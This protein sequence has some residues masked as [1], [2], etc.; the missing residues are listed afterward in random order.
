MNFYARDRINIHLQKM[1]KNFVS[2]NWKGFYHHN[3][4]IKGARKETMYVVCKLILACPAVPPSKALGLPHLRA[5]LTFLSRKT[6]LL[7]V[8]VFGGCWSY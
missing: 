2:K 3:K 5:W 4:N 1:E 7:A 8:G 6:G